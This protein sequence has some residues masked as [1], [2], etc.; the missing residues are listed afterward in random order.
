MY[1]NQKSDFKNT[2]AKSKDGF[3]LQQTELKKL[4]RAPNHDIESVQ[5]WHYNHNTAINEEEQAYLTKPHDL[6]ALL[7]RTKSPLRR[8]LERSKVFRLWLM[9]RK[10]TS[11]PTL[12]VYD[13]KEF[14]HISD[15]RVDRCVNT[16]VVAIG[17]AML[18]GPIWILNGLNS[19]KEKLATITAFVVLFLGIVGGAS[20]AKIWEALAATAA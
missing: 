17:I 1:P 14:T 10:V 4:P 13:K 19:Q 9:W 16:V 18:V 12:P 6:F 3:I 11:D 5:N 15:N 20:V 8:L 2:L 7:P